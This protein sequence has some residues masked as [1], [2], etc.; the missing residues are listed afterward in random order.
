MWELK[1][2]QFYS[3]SEIPVNVEFNKD[4]FKQLVQ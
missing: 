1:E 4:A 3:E 2:N